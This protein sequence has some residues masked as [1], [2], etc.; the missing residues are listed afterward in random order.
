MRVFLPQPSAFWLRDCPFSVLWPCSTPWLSQDRSWQSSGRRRSSS[1]TPV[2]QGRTFLFVAGPACDAPISPVA[3]V[4]GPLVDEPRGRLLED[5]GSRLEA[6]PETLAV[7]T[8]ANRDSAAHPVMASIGTRTRID[9][10]MALSPRLRWRPTG[11]G[12]R[13]RGLPTHTPRHQRDR[14][15]RC[16]PTGSAFT[17][18]GLSDRGD[19]RPRRAR[20]V[21]SDP[22]AFTEASIR[23][24]FSVQGLLMTTAPTRSD[25]ETVASGRAP[26]SQMDEKDAISG[27]K[28]GTARTV[29]ETMSVPSLLPR[30]GS[31]TA[32]IRKSLFRQ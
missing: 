18:A 2:D 3:L 25:H 7:D 11:R 6:P 19:A 23:Y 1:A 31:A 16:I 26:G 4:S 9:G 21:I 32:K 29:D 17:Y 8:G 15:A 13:G 14:S 30:S 27:A 20:W 22:A 5:S 12:Q 28:L 24:P 10:R